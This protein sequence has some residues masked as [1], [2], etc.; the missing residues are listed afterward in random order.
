M[1]VVNEESSA[2]GVLVAVCRERA[3]GERRVALTPEET[4]R[5]MAKGARVRVERGAGTPAGFPDESTRSPARSS[6]PTRR[7]RWTEPGSC[8]RVAP[9]SA[10]EIAAL[11]ASALV[12]STCARSTSPRSS[13]RWPRAA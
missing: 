10:E 1:T 5:L 12:I 11:P 2:G 4:G 6:S 8:L 9:P 3:D 7:P 13:R